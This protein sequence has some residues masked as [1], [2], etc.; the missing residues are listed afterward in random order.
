MNTDNASE[1]E[2]HPG[3]IIL[4]QINALDFFARARWG[5][6]FPKDHGLLL[7]DNGL[8]MNCARNLKIQVILDPS[9][10]YTVKFLRYSPKTFECK[11]LAEMSDVYAESLV[12]VIDGMRRDNL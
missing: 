7:I 4:Q 6:K 12:Q 1:T 5:V 3:Q 9:D 11:T 2:T 10:T 8:Q